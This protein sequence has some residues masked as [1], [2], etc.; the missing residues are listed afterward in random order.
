MPI[1]HTHNSGRNWIM[2]LDFSHFLNV[3]DLAMFVR[4][5]KYF[6]CAIVFTLMALC[7][8]AAD[9]KTLYIITIYGDQK[10]NGQL[11]MKNDCDEIIK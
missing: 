1:N 2:P 6:L 8:Q 4:S 7:L 5:T 11:L 3:Q 10:F 9:A